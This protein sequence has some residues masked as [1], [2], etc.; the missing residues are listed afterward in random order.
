MNVRNRLEHM[1]DAMEIDCTGL[2]KA[3]ECK[4]SEDEAC[5]KD[6]EGRIY[7]VNGLELDIEEPGQPHIGIYTDSQGYQP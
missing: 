3:P 2:E 6:D 4:R 7:H 1:L 5:F